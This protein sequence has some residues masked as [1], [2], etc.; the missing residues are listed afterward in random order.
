MTVADDDLCIGP[1]IDQQD[2]VVF[3]VQSNGQQVGRHV[4]A[5]V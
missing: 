4:G 3:L 5:D 2:D 1:H